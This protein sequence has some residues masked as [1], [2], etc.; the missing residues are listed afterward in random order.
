MQ[1][2]L[3]EYFKARSTSPFH[4]GKDLLRTFIDCALKM[5]RW[6]EGGACPALSDPPHAA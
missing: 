4:L 2:T 6:E 1:Q 5:V 3:C